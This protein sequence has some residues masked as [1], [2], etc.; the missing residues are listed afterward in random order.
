MRKD[1]NVNFNT[2][3]SD[4]KGFNDINSDKEEKDLEKYKRTALKSDQYDLPN[5]NRL[6][7]N[8]VTKTWQD[9]SKKQIDDKLKAVKKL[10]KINIKSFEEIIGEDYAFGKELNSENFFISL[11]KDIKGYLDDIKRLIPINRG[12][13][14]THNILLEI[15][16][17][18]NNITKIITDRY[19][20]T[21]GSFPNSKIESPI[22]P[23]KI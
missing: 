21:S 6:R 1:N 22:D 2:T 8:K 13:I 12:N 7:Y 17:N 16:S 20:D 15:N 3:Q 10:E 18:L 4:V 14:D 5:T 23:R 9:V 11:E 19:K